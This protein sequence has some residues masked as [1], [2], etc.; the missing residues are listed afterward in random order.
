MSEG[1]GQNTPRVFGMTRAS[2]SKQ[3]ASPATQRDIMERAC[4]SLELG[5]P[6]WLDEPLGTSGRSLKFAQRPMGIWALKNLRRDD[7]LV[8]TEIRTIGRN[9]IDAY[10]TVETF[11]NRGVRVVILKGFG[12]NV[13]DL[14]KSTDRLFLAILA[15]AA[16]EEAARVSE[17]TKDALQHLRAAG[18]ATGKKH[19]HY[20][21]AFDAAGKEISPGEYNKQ[22]G[23]WKQN[24]PDKQLLDQLIQ[25]LTLQ[26]HVKARG[27][28]LLAYCRAQ[29]FVDRSGRQWWN[30][31]VYLGPSGLYTNAISKALKQ[32][33]RMAVRGELPDEFCQKILAITGD[34]PIDVAPKWKYKVPRGTIAAQAAADD[35]ETWDPAKWREWWHQ[36][37]AAGGRD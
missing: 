21:Q 15:W 35:R 32:V 8:V 36:Q 30:G 27:P 26:R 5:T 20:I 11:F 10:A 33:R 31:T 7:T 3:V 2:T 9:F 14:N 13:I 16:D 6:L 19:F 25:L 1:N 4:Q 18:L 17:R 34:T 12:G 28:L 37:V 24:V 23:H 29:K 22:L